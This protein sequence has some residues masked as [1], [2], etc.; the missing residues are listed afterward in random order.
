MLTD[1]EVIILGHGLKD[2]GKKESFVI[3]LSNDA[4]G[5]LIDAL[6]LS[7]DTKWTA[8]TPI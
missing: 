2:V 1:D 5:D 3:R 6:K 8:G 4:C 7:F